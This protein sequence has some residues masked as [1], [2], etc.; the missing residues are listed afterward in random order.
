LFK[1]KSVEEEDGIRDGLSF[2]IQQLLAS[3]QELPL[4]QERFFFFVFMC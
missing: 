1:L 2:I 3:P 4:L